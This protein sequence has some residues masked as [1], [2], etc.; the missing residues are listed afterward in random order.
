MNMAESFVNENSRY[1]DF[2]KFNIYANLSSN[3]GARSRLTWGLM[4]GNPRITVFT[5]DPSDTVDNKVI[6]FNMTFE[7]LYM[8]FSIMEKTAKHQGEI[9]HGFEYS[10]RVYEN[11]KPTNETVRVSKLVIGKDSE[12][13]CWM[14]VVAPNRP[15]IKFDFNIGTQTTICDQNGA[16]LRDDFISAGTMLGTVTGLKAAYGGIL[17]EIFMNPPPREDAKPINTG[18]VEGNLGFDN[19]VAF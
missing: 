5:N 13:I 11:N 18:P 1:R 3:S 12:G 2:Q 6:P 9:K 17:T 19:D 7:I 16:P 4:N 8:V 10:R 15:N 14:S